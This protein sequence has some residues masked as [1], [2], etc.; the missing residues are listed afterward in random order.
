M[1]WLVCI[2][3]ITNF[4]IGFSQEPEIDAL[5]KGCKLIDGTGNAWRQADVAIVKDKIWAVSPLINLPAKEVVNAQGLYLV[6]GFIDVHVHAEGSI[7][8]RPE[9]LNFL[10]DGVTSVI[11]G[12]CGGSN[13][14]L[15][16]Y[17]NRLDS[18]GLGLNLASLIGHNTI[19]R[20]VMGNANRPPTA[21]ELNNMQQLIASAMQHGAVGLS[22]G[23]IYVPGTYA[24]TA[25]IVA[26]A[27]EASRYGGVYASHIR[28]EGDQLFNAIDEAI[29]I[30]EKAQLPVEISHFKSSGKPNWFQASQMVERITSAR[31]RGV[32]VTVDQYPYTAS[33]TRLDVLLPTWALEGEAEEVIQRLQDKDQIKTITM[34]MKSSLKKSKFKNY[35]YAVVG[36]CAWDTTL[37]AKSITDI[38]LQKFGKKG[39]NSEISTILWMMTKGGAQMIYHKMHVSDVEALLK[40]P[41]NMVASDAGI[42]AFGVGA[43]HPRAYGTNMTILGEFV[44]EKKVLQMEEAI[45]K[46]T[47]LPA[48]KFNLTG[49]GLIIPGYYADLVLLDMDK[50]GAHAT[51]QKPHAYSTGVKCLWINGRQVIKDEVHLPIKSGR[52]LY[53]PGKNLK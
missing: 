27:K 8:H 15:E 26:L 34:A 10:Y 21:E 4:K 11:T 1:K 29:A 43:P 44:R 49:R 23:L 13:V 31:A 22:T 50:T 17:F 6:P 47:S 51:Y 30:G 12:N 36:F 46:M 7:E 19:R 20:A 40:Y 3:L 41:F 24:E 53:G 35:S 28:D 14:N 32:E 38:T 39:V 2:F 9:A 48:T 18:I 37:N 42:P 33:S 25:E 5:I 45:R 16:Q 52:I